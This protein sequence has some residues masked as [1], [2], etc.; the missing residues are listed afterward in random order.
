MYDK[1][2]G[3]K[4]DYNQAV[5][6]YHKAAEQ[7]Y[8]KAQD[9]LS[10]MYYEGL[11]VTQDYV[12][13]HILWKLGSVNSDVNSLKNS[14]KYRSVAEDKVKTYNRDIVTSKLAEKVAFK[15]IRTN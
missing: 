7:G 2:Q 13:A 9:N 15:K 4:Q 11:G 14:S 8:A 1:G 5:A 12:K 3:V 6:W 10:I